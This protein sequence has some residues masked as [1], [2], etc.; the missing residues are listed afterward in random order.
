MTVGK[1]GSFTEEAWSEYSRERDS[2]QGELS[3]EDVDLSKPVS[4]KLATEAP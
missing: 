1:T 2:E 3:C 4:M